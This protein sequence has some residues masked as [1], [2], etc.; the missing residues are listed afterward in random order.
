MKLELHPRAIENF[1]RKIKE[2]KNQFRF[3]IENKRETKTGVNPN[4]HVTANLDST[5]IIGEIKQSMRDKSGNTTARM[6]SVRGKSLGLFDDDYK[7]LRQIAEN[8]QKSTNPKYVASIDLISESIF[9]WLKQNYFGKTASEPTEY[10]LSDCEKCIEDAEIWIP[11]SHLHIQSP[12]NLGNITFKTI[13]KKFMDEYELS[14]KLNIPDKENLVK[15]EHYFERKRS[16]I[17]NL[18]VATMRIEAEPKQAYK[19]AYEETDRAMSILRFFSPTNLFPRKICYCAPIDKQH[20]DMDMFLIVK[21]G[22]VIKENSGISDKSVEYWNLS[23]KDLDSYAKVGL[24]FLGSL[25]TKSKNDLTDFQEKLLEAIFIYSKASLAKQLSDRL[26][27]TLVAL[28]TIFLKDENEPIQDNIS[29]RM[30]YMHKVSLE[31]RKKIIKNIKDTYGLRSAFIHHGKQVSEENLEIL[32]KF[33]VDTWL[34]L[35][36]VI[37]FAYEGFTKQQFFEELENRRIGG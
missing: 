30:A 4:I 19:I 34:C 27:Y 5:D 25:L 33:M 12:F 28:E 20:M 21:D 1:D 15:I 7:T 3:T 13:T 16:K 32:K 6:F 18:A 22:K 35:T 8:I 26:I 2:L 10:V 23:S 9:E 29:L 24:G 14:H 11:I 36:Q 31:E 17:Q 37:S